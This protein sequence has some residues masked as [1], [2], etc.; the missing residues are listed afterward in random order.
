[1]KYLRPAADWALHNDHYRKGLGF[2][3]S[4]MIGIIN[5][6]TRQNYTNFYNRYVFGTE[7]PDYDRIFGY[8]GYQLIHVHES[9]LKVFHDL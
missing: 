1:M 9:R 8:A 5:R 4:E 3:T 2:T 7:V 6:I